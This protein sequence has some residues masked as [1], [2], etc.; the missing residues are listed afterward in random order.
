MVDDPFG[1]FDGFGT[2]ELKM[3]ARLMMPWESVERFQIG[4]LAA[5]VLFQ[6]GSP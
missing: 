2:L 3:R 1:G 4:T 6:N 5:T